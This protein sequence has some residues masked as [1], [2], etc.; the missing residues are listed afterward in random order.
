MHIKELEGKLGYDF[1]N[2]DLLE[3]ALIH[4]SS[5]NTLNNERLEFLGDAV[6]NSI[7]SQYLFLKFP[8]EK[9][10]LLT[11]MRSHLVKGETLTKKAIEIGIIEF[12]KLSKGTAKLSEN[13]KHSILEGSIE[14]I[15]GAVFLDSDWKR[16]EAFILNLFK[17]ELS[18]IGIDQEFRDAKTE[19]QEL[20]QSKKLELPKYDTSESKIGFDCEIFIDGK[21]FIGSGNSKRYS[22][23]AVAQEAL[24]YLKDKNA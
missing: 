4:K 6:L 22:E 15:I 12:I 5:N 11:R 9:E 24:N 2:L 23:I 8:N 19:L 14:S 7:I 17:Q 3:L 20:L 1:E 16:V 21:R 10:G 13:R 18:S